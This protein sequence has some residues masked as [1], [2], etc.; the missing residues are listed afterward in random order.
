MEPRRRRM[1]RRSETRETFMSKFHVRRMGAPA[2][3]FL[4]A[5]G[6]LAACGGSDDVAAF[7]D[8]VAELEESD[9]MEGLNPSDPE[10]IDAVIATFD[11]LATSAPDE[12]SAD[13][14]S[15]SATMKSMAEAVQS[16]DTDALTDMMGDLEEMAEIGER[17][18]DYTSANC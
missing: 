8:K 16:G 3:A 17:L 12:I 4:F 6:G 5:I 2:L 11:D 13:V 9:P 14:E 1:S 15:V 7:C 10:S 18:D